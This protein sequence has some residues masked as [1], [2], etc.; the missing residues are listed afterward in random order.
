MSA[1]LTLDRC[2]EMRW[3]VCPFQCATD[4]TPKGVLLVNSNVQWGSLRMDAHLDGANLD[5]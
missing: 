5:R 4:V 2:T 1:W 3:G